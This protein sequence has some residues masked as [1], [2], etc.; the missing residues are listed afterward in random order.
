MISIIV[1]LGIVFLLLILAEYLRRKQ[2]IKGEISRKFVH[3]SVGSFVAF[4]PFFMT[5]NEVRVMCL[6][7]LIVVLIDR[8]THF[9]KSVH[10]VKRRTAGDIF[11]PVGI[12]LAT[13]VSSS[14]WIFSIAILHLSLGDGF[15]AI[16]GNKYGKDY[17]YS[18]FHQKKSSIGSVTFWFVSLVLTGIMLLFMPTN[19]QDVAL[20]LIF[21]LPVLTAG[22]E[23][24]SIFGLDNIT[25]PVVVAL[26]LSL[27]QVIG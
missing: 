12:G 6:A 3:I 21:G 13:Y 18:I 23:S 22:L 5:W 7:F 16:V 14:P 9:F 4:W 8:H 1:S 25:V 10:D 26:L 19:L 11:F 15:A 20:P 17:A 24:I 27:L 2:H